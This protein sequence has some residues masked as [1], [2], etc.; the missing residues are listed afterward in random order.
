MQGTLL[1]FLETGEIQRVGATGT[2]VRANVRIIAATNRDLYAAVASGAFRQDLFYR[3]DVIHLI[4]APL[5]ERRA[6]IPALLEH[7]LEYYVAR[8]R[9]SPRAWS[10]EAVDL[11][12]AYG[13]PGNVRQLKNVVERIVLRSAG[14]R[15]LI[16]DVP[17]DI[18]PSATAA[19]CH[20]GNGSAVHDLRQRLESGESCACS[21]CRTPTTGNS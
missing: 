18:H 8:H 21:T 10:P 7:F 4:V 19:S 17:R 20:G 6:D 1:R 14:A 11:L 3:L 15:V 5:R 2:I 9:A 12:S 16:D 13:W